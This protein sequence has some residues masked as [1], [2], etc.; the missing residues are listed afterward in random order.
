METESSLPCSQEPATSP[1]P[2]PY[3]SDATCP[4]HLILLDL[5]TLI[6]VDNER[7]VKFLIIQSSPASCNFVPLK[8]KYSP[9]RPVLKHP[10]CVFFP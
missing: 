3:D 5:I 10:V 7:G 1:Y 9:Q 8:S 2:E 4:T 6:I